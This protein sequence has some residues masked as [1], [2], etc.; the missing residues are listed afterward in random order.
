MVTQ[1]PRLFHRYHNTNV[2]LLFIIGVDTSEVQVT[3]HI[4]NN[5]IHA[6]EL[7]SQ[8]YYY[9]V[10]VVCTISYPSMFASAGLSDTVD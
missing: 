1:P 5:N 10:G 3:P 6:H 8:V 9:I 7:S 4:K 2:R